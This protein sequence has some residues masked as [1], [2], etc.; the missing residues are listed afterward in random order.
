LGVNLGLKQQLRTDILLCHILKKNANRVRQHLILKFYMRLILFCKRFVIKSMTASQ[1]TNSNIEKFCIL[2]TMSSCVLCE[3][4]T[5]QTSEETLLSS[6]R[7]WGAI[8]CSGRRGLQNLAGDG[9]TG[10]VEESERKVGKL[11]I[12]R[13]LFWN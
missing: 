6:G 8:D 3:L 4:Y 2:S 9:G 5:K 13:I 1:K 10:G 11:C 12:L 7:S